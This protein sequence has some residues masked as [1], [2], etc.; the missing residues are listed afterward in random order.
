MNALLREENPGA[1][2]SI[3]DSAYYLTIKRDFRSFGVG[4]EVFSM[5]AHFNTELRSHI[6][7]SEVNFGNPVVYNNTY[8]HRLVED[9]DDNDRY[10]DTWYTNRPFIWNGQSDLDGVFPGLDEDNDGVPDTNRDF[11]ATPDYLE[12]FLTY[13]VDPQIFDYGL[14]LNHNDYIDERENDLQPDLP[15]DPGLR[16]RHVYGTFK[17][18]RGARM[19]LGLLDAEQIAA[20][21]PSESLYARLG[22][23]RRIPSLGRFR[24]ALFTERVRDGVE[25][26]LSVYSDEVLTAAEQ[27]RREF[28][29]F[30]RNIRIS[31]F[32]EVPREDPLLFKNSTYSR[33]FVDARWT[34]LPGLNIHNKVKYE[35]NQ[36]L[37]GELYDGTLQ[38]GRTLSRWAMVHRLDYLWPIR[39]KLSLFSGLKYRFLREWQTGDV[40][41]QHER[42]IIPIL[43]L[44]YD[45]TLRTR[46]QFGVEGLG[47]L[48]PYSVVDLAQPENDFEQYDYVLMLT[49]NSKY[50][51]YILSTNAGLSRRHRVFDE[52]SVAEVK[53]E[54]FTAVFI[55]VILGFEEET[56]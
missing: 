18:I 16:G 47:T 30:Q 55:N 15:Y 45:L 11:D 9:N 31:P 14:D 24:G 25:D 46:L 21:D 26:P 27:L 5:G 22:Y 1:R 54:K 4:A 6:G 10:P 43:K 33:F 37:D 3:D 32:L 39:P 8:L 17:P 42:H 12:P 48:L 13:D 44:N 40:T 19:T 51:G 36:Q 50:F 56:Y 35:I 49:N 7:R 52:P 53:D 28:G 2:S 29:G 23:E 41:T 34:T 20:G 38:E